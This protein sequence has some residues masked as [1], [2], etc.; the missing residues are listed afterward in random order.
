MTIQRL[1]NQKIASRDFYLTQ[2][3]L[4]QD[5]VIQLVARQQTGFYLTC[6]T[7]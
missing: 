7:P 5:E 3:Y 4:L 1:T 6:R 2:L